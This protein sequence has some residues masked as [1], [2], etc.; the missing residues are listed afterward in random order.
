MMDGEE[1]EKGRG[2]AVVMALKK[3]CGGVPKESKGGQSY[4]TV[5]RGGQV[6]YLNNDNGQSSEKDKR[7]QLG[8]SC[9]TERVVSGSHDSHDD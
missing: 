3:G 5:E 2:D 8:S 4:A 9:H 7:E 1:V 6:R